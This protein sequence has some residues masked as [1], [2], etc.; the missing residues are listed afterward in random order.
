MD[1]WILS[2]LE[3]T[4]IKVTK[5]LDKFQS[6]PATVV[7]EKFVNDF[8]TWYI[9]RSRDRVNAYETMY[10]C[11]ITLSKLLAPFM[12]YISDNIYKNLTGEESVHLADWP[13][14]DKSLVDLKLEDDMKKAR[15]VVEKIHAQRKLKELKVRQPLAKVTII[16][17]SFGTTNLH[18]VILEETNIKKLEF[19]DEDKDFEIILDVKLTPD[20]KAEGAAREL[21]RQIQKLRRKANIK[22]DQKIIL[23]IPSYPKEFEDYIK[24]KT[25]ATSIVKG[26][27]LKIE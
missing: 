1:K 21:V 23:T 20:L 27:T 11:L 18:Q 26:Q 5:S 15:E 10:H 9:R 7:L 24:Q 4:I 19:T 22:L 25:L 13:K 3:N 2:R 12:P 14:V 6:A 16:G 17:K 8:S